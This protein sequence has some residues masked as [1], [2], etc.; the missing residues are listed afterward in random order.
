MLPGMWQC[1][2][3]GARGPYGGE[4]EG[5]EAVTMALLWQQQL[6]LAAASC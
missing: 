6:L 4:H 5:E 1:P 3:L 2:A